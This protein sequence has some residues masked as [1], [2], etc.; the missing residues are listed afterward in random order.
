MLKE[1]EMYG[2][3]LEDE[4]MKFH[5]SM[6]VGGRVKYFIKPDSI[7]NLINIINLFKIKKEPYMV[8]GRGSNVIFPD[9]DMNLSIICLN[10]TI[11]Y[12]EINQEHII[13]GAGYSIQKLAKQ[14]SKQGL[15]GLEFAGGIP[16]SVGGAI[17]MN[18]GAHSGCIGDVV[19]YVKTIDQDGNIKIYHHQDCQFAYRYSIFQTNQEIIIEAAFNLKQDDPSIV[20]KKML[21]NL[22]YR[23]E[24][25]PLDLPSC[26]SVFKNPANTSAG[27]LIDQAGLKGYQIGGA[28]VSMKHANFIVNMKDASSYDIIQLQDYIKKVIKEKYQIELISEIRILKGIDARS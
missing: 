24:L 3:V 10:N 27:Y 18:A 26:G 28:Q 16:G 11:D 2:S 13:V 19:N 7:D 1:L 14:L 17:F 5:T 12:L 15:S 8:L 25:Q 4:S 23:K 9:Y 20:F 6:R 21:G 22:S